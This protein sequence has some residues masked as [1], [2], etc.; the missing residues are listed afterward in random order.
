MSEPVSVIPDELHRV[1]SALAN[2]SHDMAGLQ[3]DLHSAAWACGDRSLGNAFGEF[4]DRLHA[5]RD[6]LVGLVGDLSAAFRS[7]AFSYE[8][9][10]A[11][12]SSA[13]RP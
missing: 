2:A 6:D 12:I 5:W 11:M 10:E 3:V 4:G 13:W 1:A 8:E 7:A 9:H